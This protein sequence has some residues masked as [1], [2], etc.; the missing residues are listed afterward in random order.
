MIQGM[1]SY[2]PEPSVS[3]ETK[4]LGKTAQSEVNQ[5][6]YVLQAF[7]LVKKGSV[8]NFKCSSK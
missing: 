5:A 3:Y 8:Y 7:V 6:L 4:R 2:H 1:F